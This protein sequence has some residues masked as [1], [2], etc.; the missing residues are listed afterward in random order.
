SFEKIKVCT[1]Y[2]LE[3]GTITDEFPYDIVDSEVKPIY[4]ELE[5]WNC[6]LD[7]ISSFTEMPKPLKDYIAYIE[8]KLG[9]PINL[10][11]VGPDRT[12]TIL[13]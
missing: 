4:E 5:G 1:Q 7:S 10:V 13:R 3:D 2:E 6:S 9:V 8:E 12:Q 11:S